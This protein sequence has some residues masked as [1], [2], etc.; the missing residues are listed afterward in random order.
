MINFLFAITWN[1]QFFIES[2]FVHKE[3]ATYGAAVDKSSGTY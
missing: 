2:H 1:P 3:L